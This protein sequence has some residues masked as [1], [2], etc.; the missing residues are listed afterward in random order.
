MM[1]RL[2]WVPVFL[3]LAGVAECQTNAPAVPAGRPRIGLVLGGGGALG[4]A[5]IGVLRTLEEMRIPIDRIA[6]TS[7]GS[8]IAGLY[9]AGLSP[10]EIAGA[11]TRLDW[12]DVLKDQTPYRDLDFRRKEESTRYLMDME[13]G[14]QGFRLLFPHGL[15]SGQKFNNLMQSLTVNAAGVT[16][17]DNLNIPYRAVATDLR[18]GRPVVL[19]RGNLA[20]AMRASMAVPGVFTPVELN[21][22][23]LVDGGLVNNLPVDIVKAM[24]ADIIIAVDVGA[25]EAKAGEK[26]D[27]RDLGAILGRTYTIMQ[28]PKDDARREAANILIEPDLVGWSASDFHRGAELIP[29]GQL[30]VLA[31]SNALARLSVAEP[32]YASWRNK[33]RAQRQDAMTIRSIQITGN[34]T[35]PTTTI[36]KRMEIQPGETADPDRIHR[37]VA[38]IHGMGD[39]QTVTHR[40]LPTDKPGEYDL[41]IETREKYWGPGYVHTGLRLESDMSGSSSWSMLLNLRRAGLNDL[42]GETRIDLEGGRRQAVVGE[43]YQPLQDRGFVFVAPAVEVSSESQNIYED[44]R[45]T[46]EYEED[47]LLGR[48]DVGSQYKEYGECRVGVLVGSMDAAPEV[49]ATNLPTVD[50]QLGAVTAQ[51]TVDRLDARVFARHGSY[52]RVHGFF[53]SDD[54]GADDTYNKVEGRI[55]GL[56]SWGDHTGGI[57]F[58]GGHSLGS[59]V[60]FYDQFRVGGMMMFPGIPIDG[61][62]GSYYGIV[63]LNYSYRIGRLSPSTGKGIY[64]LA[65]VT[66]GNV[67]Q[68]TDEVDLDDLIVS[69]M[70]GLALDTVL[71]PIAMGAG[72]AEDRELELYLSVGTLF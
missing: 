66:A 50:P 51:L 18:S 71:G 42:G 1:S 34:Q 61:L 68:T 39:F 17:F 53:S 46:A 69:G 27:F 5:H 30:A 41:A 40:L 6:G 54:L 16:V 9:A 60:P 2:F 43:W 26:S 28:R 44:E 14:V 55:H 52:V 65:G 45:K 11:L 22:F 8:I 64:A 35:V 29:R 63:D 3:V 10:D 37:D 48:F 31:H 32:A 59:D 70:L 33:Q 38:R 67:W 62:R 47:L 20:V 36:A 72:L 25:S 57:T 58:F 19:D 23:L 13:L 7:M 49:G 15:A 21:G 12:W 4:I 56:S 24:G